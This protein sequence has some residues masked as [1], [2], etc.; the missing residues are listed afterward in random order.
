MRRILVMVLVTALLLGCARGAAEGPAPAATNTPRPALTLTPLADVQVLPRSERP[1]VV[2]ILTDD[3]DLLL[4]TIDYMPQLQELLVKQGLTVENFLISHPLCCPARVTFLRSQYTHNHGIYRNDQPNGGFEQFYYL[5]HETSTLA[6]WLQAAGYRT[7]LLGKYLNGYPF[8]EDRLY[9][10]IGWDEWY[11]GVGGAPFAGFQ[12]TLNENGAFVNYEET[13]EGESQFITDVLARKAG[14][15]I[16]RSS[17]AG[18]PFFVHLSTYAPHLPVKAAPRHEWL[19]PDLTAPRTASFNQEDVSDKHAGIRFDP[20]LTEDEIGDLDWEYRSRVLGMQAVDDMIAYL[21]DV[22]Q[23][24]GELD[25]TYFIFTSDNGYH[26]GQHRLRNGKGE[27]YD[28]DTRVPFIVRGPG[29]APDTTLEGYLTGNVDFAPTIAQLAGVVPPDYVDG[30]SMAGFFRG[31]RPAPEEWRAGYLLEFYGYNERD[32]PPDAP[33]P[34]PVYL[35]LRTQDYLY[36]EFEDGFI[37]LYD[38]RTDPDQMENIAATA[39][40]DLQEYLSDWLN[41]LSTCADAQCRALDREPAR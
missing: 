39:D 20:P 4:G 2:F 32:T 8:R 10:P 17:A 16:Q 36:V 37:E 22:L 26:L 28:E 19:F 31:E 15:F 3:L 34:T 18:A 7:A 29:I 1:N 13:G 21:L 14:E 25:N 11:T 27:P 40:P 6:T 12:Y 9:V 5:E 30:R 33:A 23:A 41:A 35:G 24:T 38:L